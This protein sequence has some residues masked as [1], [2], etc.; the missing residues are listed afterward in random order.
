MRCKQSREHD[1]KGYFRSHTTRNLANTASQPSGNHLTIFQLHFA[2]TN[3]SEYPPT[4]PVACS[5]CTNIWTSTN[6]CFASYWPQSCVEA[7]PTGDRQDRSIR[8]N[9]VAANVKSTSDFQVDN[10]QLQATG[11]H[12]ATCNDDGKLMLPLQFD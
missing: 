3:I 11:R 7:V 12:C 10:W 9:R 6:E 5:Q 2:S 1:S 4:Y 8:F